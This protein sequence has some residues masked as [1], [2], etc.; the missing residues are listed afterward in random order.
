MFTVEERERIRARL[1]EVAEA[2]DRVVAAAVVGAEA[3]GRV[4]RWSD[5]DLTFA[6]RDGVAAAGVIESFTAIMAAEFGAEHL[7]DLPAGPSLYRVFLV[8]GALQV[9]LSFTPAAEFGARGPEFRLLWG[10]AVERPFAP[11]PDAAY[12]FGLA[13]HHLVRARFCIERGRLWQSEYWISGARDEGLALACLSRGLPAANGRGFDRLPA[14]VLAR[15]EAGIVRSL[16]KEELL[17]ALGETVEALLAEA[18]DERA[19]RLAP[20]LR[21]LV[22]SAGARRAGEPDR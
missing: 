21:A 14:T 13:V 5:L 1:L 8:P 22:R 11:Q 2:D 12:R 6:V 19:A 15:Y 4:D 9:D 3:G 20:E 17:R 16:E 18:D 7:F 10:E